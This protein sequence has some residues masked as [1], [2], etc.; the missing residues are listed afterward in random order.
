MYKLLSTYVQKQC[1]LGHLPFSSPVSLLMKS[2]IANAEPSGIPHF[3]SLSSVSLKK[4]RPVI[5]FS[6][7]ILKSS[8]SRYKCSYKIPISFF[9]SHFLISSASVSDIA[10][11]V[12]SEKKVL[13]FEI[14]L[15]D[16]IINTLVN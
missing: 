15:G 12:S 13:R 1:R 3:S 2:T 11:L 14:F 10:Y 6:R 16:P 7:I 4:I 9:V 8:P 5:F